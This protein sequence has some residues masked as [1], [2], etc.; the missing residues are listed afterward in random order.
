MDVGTSTYCI[1]RNIGDDTLI[2]IGG[3]S[4]LEY[5]DGDDSQIPSRLPFEGIFNPLATIND[6][7]G[8]LIIVENE[9]RF[10]KYNKVMRSWSE[11]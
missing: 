9:N 3:N 11:S 5:V 10:W 4:R 1:L 6:Q 8:A 7:E 2:L